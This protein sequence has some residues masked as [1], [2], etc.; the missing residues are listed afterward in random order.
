MSTIPV[1]PDQLPRDQPVAT[2]DDPSPGWRRINL[3]EVVRS[4]DQVW[5]WMPRPHW[6]LSSYY[7]AEGLVHDGKATYRRPASV[8]AWANVLFPVI[9]KVVEG[10]WRYWRTGRFV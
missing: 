7:T 10:Y 1:P 8:R 2:P 6:R 5:A 9:A 4:Y 3:G